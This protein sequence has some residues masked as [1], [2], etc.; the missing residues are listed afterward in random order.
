MFHDEALD[1]DCDPS[2]LD[3]PMND[4]TLDLAL[5]PRRL[6]FRDDDHDENAKLKMEDEYQEFDDYTTGRLSRSL[7]TPSLGNRLSLASMPTLG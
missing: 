5:S 6:T 2:D 1:D 4:P 3:D 7:P